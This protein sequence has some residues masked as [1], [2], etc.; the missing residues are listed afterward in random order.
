MRALQLARDASDGE[1]VLCDIIARAPIAS[2]GG[3]LKAAVLEQKGYC[4]TVHFRLDDKF[5]LFTRQVLLETAKPLANFF[6]G[7]RIIEREHRRAVSDRGELR[8]RLPA[9]VLGGGVCC[10]QLRMPGFEVRQF[11]VEGVVFL[12]GDAGS[13]LLVVAPVMFFDEPAELF[14]TSLRGGWV[15]GFGYQAN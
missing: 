6:L 13:G 8:E 3:I 10:D 15:H 12:V 7:I 2:R 4:Y 9:N 14:G 1:D 5:D 11:A